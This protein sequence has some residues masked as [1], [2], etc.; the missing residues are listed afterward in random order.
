[1]SEPNQPPRPDAPEP[2]SDQLPLEDTLVDRGVDD[3]LD[4][5]YSP[6]DRPRTN[7]WGETPLEEELGESL[8]RRLA[9]EE[10][11]AWEP[12]QGPDAHREADRTGR[13]AVDDDEDSDPTGV[14]SQ[15]TMADDV[16]VAG[17]G[18]SAEEAAMHLVPEEGEPA[19]PLDGNEPPLDEPAAPWQDGSQAP[20]SDDD[21][22]TPDGDAP[23]PR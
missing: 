7:R 9:Q 23:P 22:L 19:P 21:D 13:L 20:T 10:P 12:G 5:G 15:H 18:A 3:V 11:E 17:G 1:M 16:G 14:G 6:P 4:E 8:D 2:D